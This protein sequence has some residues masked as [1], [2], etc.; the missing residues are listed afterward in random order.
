MRIDIVFLSFI[1][2]ILI[3]TQSA[4]SGQLSSILKNPLIATFA[5]YLSGALFISFYL[6]V[7]KEETP[8]LEVI[9]T[10]PTYL[11]IVGGVVSTFGL[12]LVYKSMPLLGLSNTLVCV[13]CGQL[14]LSLIATHY[15][16]F[17]LPQHSINTKKFFGAIIIIIGVYLVN[18]E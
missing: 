17:N 9:K 4:L 8:K 15:G 11:W 3:A 12:T 16:W 5:L 14:I 6:F 18:K 10:V 7:T 1:S 13:I 2:G